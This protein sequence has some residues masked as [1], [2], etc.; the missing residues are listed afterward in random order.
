VNGELD[1]FVVEGEVLDEVTARELVT[2]VRSGLDDLFEAIRRLWIGRAW[3]AL[4]YLTWAEMCDAEFPLRLAL[5]RD[6]RKQLEG[7]LAR[8]GMTTRAISDALG[9]GQST[10]SDDLRQLTETGQL[11]LPEKTKGLDGK[12]RPR[13]ET[14]PAD[15]DWNTDELAIRQRL[16]SGQTVVVNLRAGVHTNLIE[17][18]EAT[19]KYVRVDRRTEWGNPFE[20]PDDGDRQAVIAKYARHYLPHKDTLRDRIP[21]LR[22]KA[23]GCW[24]APEPCHADILKARADR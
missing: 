11:E 2:Y 14:K 20:I 5:P 7:S 16:Q 19:D 4:G 17:W 6:D 21:G 9:V 8:E 18:A 10:V 1:L 12:E 23:L 3:L 13:P 22:G 24:C 15:A